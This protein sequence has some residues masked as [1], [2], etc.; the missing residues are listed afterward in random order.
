MPP[1]AAKA[2]GGFF[3][4]RVPAAPPSPKCLAHQCGLTVYDSAYLALAQTLEAELFTSDRK[5][6]VRAETL[7]IVRV[8]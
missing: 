7:G 3:I 4:P 5:L 6:A 1:S 8:V 2:G